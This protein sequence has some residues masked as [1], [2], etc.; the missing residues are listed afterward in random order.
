MLAMLT[1]S[2]K[3]G[4]SG[5]LLLAACSLP[6]VSKGCIDYLE[7][8]YSPMKA[9]EVKVS[10]AIVVLSGGN[11]RIFGG[12]ELVKEE[13]APLLILTRGKL[14]WSTGQPQGEYFRKLAIQLGI[15]SKKIFLTENVE[16]TDQEAKA[17]RKLL[18]LDKSVITLVTSAFHLPRAQLV[19]E[20]A[21]FEVVPFP[22]D[23][24][25]SED[26]RTIMDFIPSADS[27]ADTSH[28]IREIIGRVYYTL[29]Y[30]PNAHPI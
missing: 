26:R 14:P 27:L 16:N 8:D 23:F 13:K 20:A 25:R 15:P 22:V 5:I 2:K 6:I 1:R 21:G 24:R 28:F 18:S 17:T 9:A 12:I 10:D 29:K 19:F 3:V 30:Q 7:K 11:H 4:L